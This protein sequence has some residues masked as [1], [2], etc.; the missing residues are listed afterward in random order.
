MEKARGV[1]I[2]LSASKGIHLMDLREE[3]SRKERERNSGRKE[4]RERGGMKGRRKGQREG[5]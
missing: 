2:L 5:G 3:L 4:E 1:S